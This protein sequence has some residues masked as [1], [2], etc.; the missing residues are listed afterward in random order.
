MTMT[1]ANAT[2]AMDVVLPRQDGGAAMARATALDSR[3]ITGR[4]KREHA[5]LRTLLDD[6]D[7]ACAG[8]LE[9]R[10]GGLD[11]VLRAVWELYVS[12][13]EHLAMEEALVAP[14]LRARETFGALRAEAMM[15][16]HD[17]QRRGLLELVDATEC[18]TKDI[19]ALVAQASSLVSRFRSDMALEEA[20][21]GE[22]VSDCD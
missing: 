6:V 12:F 9:H 4:I 2:S 22:L 20:S 10:S 19:D 13:E 18:D 15:A 7:R 8:A 5:I 17:D 14:A 21:F 16:E 11:E 1:R 3:D